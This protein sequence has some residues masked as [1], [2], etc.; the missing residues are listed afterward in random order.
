MA[1]KSKKDNKNKVTGNSNYPVGD[2]LIRIKNASR[3]NKKKVMA[4]N[5]KLIMAVAKALKKEGYLQSVERADGNIEVELAFFRKQP[6]LMDL[7]LVSRPGLRIYMGVEE[8]ENVKGPFIMLLS[9]P[10]GVLS[11]K[12]AL[13]KGV[14]GEV[15]VKIW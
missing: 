13:K 6:V 5:T 7:K 15:I 2:F 4:R 8:I 3:V 12:G 11:S 1:K 9:T 10:K 14:G